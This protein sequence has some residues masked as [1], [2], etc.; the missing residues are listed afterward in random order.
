MLIHFFDELFKSLNPVKYSILSQKHPS[1][2]I[3]F[4]AKLLFLT[5]ILMFILYVP[6]FSSLQDNLAN[7]IKFLDFKDVSGNWS[8]TSPI[9]IPENQPVFII[10]TTGLHSKMGKENILITE[11]YIHYKIFGNVQKIKIEDFKRIENI[12]REVGA[13]I[14]LVILVF[15]PYFA[16]LAYL[17][18]LTKYIL[19][20][21]VISFITWTLIDLTH[22]KLKL[23]QVFNTALYATVFFIPI[24][25]LSRPFGTNWLMKSAE[26]LR[27]KFFF[28]STLIYITIFL[29]IILYLMVEH[30]KTKKDY[31]HF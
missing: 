12:K 14:F 25:L 10:D 27:I 4:M 23:K 29:F 21:G 20:A 6:K 1:N 28:L 5:F 22:I 2:G 15:V 26:F 17:L 7:Q 11:N 19:I 18:L 30:K 9:K 31:D 8:A 16:L 13:L 24:E 3:K